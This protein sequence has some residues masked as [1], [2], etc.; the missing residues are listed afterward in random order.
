M[1]RERPSAAPK[2]REAADGRVQRTGDSAEKTSVGVQGG[3]TGRVDPCGDGDQAE[4]FCGWAVSRCAEH[5]EGEGLSGCDEAVGVPR[6]GQ[7]AWCFLDTSV[8]G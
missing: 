4:L 5:D 8:V 7:V 6:A 2:N 1:H 3:G